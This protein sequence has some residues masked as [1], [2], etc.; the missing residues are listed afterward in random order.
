M[1]H[2]ETLPAGFTHWPHIRRLAVATADAII[3]Q[4]AESG[5]SRSTYDLAAEYGAVLIGSSASYHYFLVNRPSTDEALI[6]TFVCEAYND[7]PAEVRPFVLEAE[8]ETTDP[9]TGDPLTTRCK[10]GELPE[11]VTPT[12]TGLIPSWVAGLPLPATDPLP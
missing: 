4:A 5:E 11:G 9:E 1:P 8:Y 2:P 7:L 10:E 6:G 12:A 3:A